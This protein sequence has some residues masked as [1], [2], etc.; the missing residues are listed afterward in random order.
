MATEMPAGGRRAVGHG[1]RRVS[2]LGSRH[3]TS[4]STCVTDWDSLWSSRLTGSMMCVPAPR[5]RSASG[6]R[7]S[8]HRAEVSGVSGH[9][10]R[11]PHASR[12]LWCVECGVEVEKSAC[13]RSRFCC[14]RTARRARPRAGPAERAGRALHGPR[15]ARAPGGDSRGPGGAAVLTG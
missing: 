12:I 10:L 14:Q 4:V 5:W 13:I 7:S 6:R 15:R 9:A 2:D 8:E 3:A 11:R 1:S